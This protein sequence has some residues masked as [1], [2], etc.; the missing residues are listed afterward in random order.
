MACLV[1]AGCSGRAANSSGSVTLGDGS[2]VALDG[3]ASAAGKGGIVGVVVDEAI[4]PLAGA[5][6]T[7]GQTKAT[8]RSDAQGRFAFADLA[9]GFYTLSVAAKGFFTVQATADVK[10]G[11]TY[12]ARVPLQ[13]DLSPQ[14]YHQTTKFHGFIEVWG[15]IAQFFVES[16]ADNELGNG[17]ALCQCIYKFTPDPGLAGLVFEAVWTET[18]PHPAGQGDNQFYALVSQ[19]GS[20]MFSD[21]YCSSP[22]RY[23]VDLKDYKPG[24]TEATLQ[25]P[26]LYVSFEQDYDMFVT[27]FY[28]A[29]QPTGWSFVQGDP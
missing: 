3:P 22:C 4:R 28:R 18:V 21:H 20:S 15:G 1:L 6:V 13:A 27:Q 23:D 10:A 14:P 8:V 25:G 2:T 9:P 5:N 29:P 16:V 11:E 24:P 19:Q 12:R 7:L 17:T 26:D